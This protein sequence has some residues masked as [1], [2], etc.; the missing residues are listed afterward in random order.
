MPNYPL[1]IVS[2]AGSLRDGSVSRLL[3]K[4]CLSVAPR[5]MMIT[6]LVIGEIPLFNADLESQGSPN[7]VLAFKRAL[8]LADGLLIVTPEYNHGIPAVTK[9]LIDWASRK[10]DNQGNVLSDLPINFIGISGGSGGTGAM[11]RSQLRQVLVYP[12]AIPM[13]KGDI[14][15]S[16]SQ[17]VFDES[18]NLLDE[19][20]KEQ[21]EK[22]LVDFKNWIDRLTK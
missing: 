2:F 5:E 1:N 7:S 3:L 6:E 9:N 18:G 22:T 13:P 16:A 14:G 10:N 15:V 8:S 12:G 17:L 19:P 11:V 21:I 20:I 4:S